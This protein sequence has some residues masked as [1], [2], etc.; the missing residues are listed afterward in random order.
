MEQ[1]FGPVLAFL[2]IW[3]ARYKT[4]YVPRGTM[5]GHVQADFEQKI[6]EFEDEQIEV[7][8]CVEETK[9]SPPQAKKDATQAFFAI[10]DHLVEKVDDVKIGGKWVK[11]VELSYIQVIKPDFDE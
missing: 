7:V 11:V 10:P 2:I 5:N 4:V 8:Q 1:I 9:K 6:A 3:F